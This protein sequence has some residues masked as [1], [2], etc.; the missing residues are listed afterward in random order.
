MHGDGKMFP[1]ERLFLIKRMPTVKVGL[2]K[3]NAIFQTHYDRIVLRF[4]QRGD[5]AESCVPYGG[6]RQS[7]K[8][9]SAI[10]GPPAR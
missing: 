6:L 2:L 10:D 9:Q 5:W 1:V 7:P 8:H 4:R 3:A